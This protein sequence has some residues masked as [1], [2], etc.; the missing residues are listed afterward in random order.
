M[1][2][3]VDRWHL[4]RPRADAEPCGEHRAAGQLLVP[5]SEHGVGKRWQVR[6]RTPAGEQKK[7]NFEKQANAQKRANQVAHSLDTG[8]FVER[9]VQRENL[10]SVGERWRESSIQRERTDSNVERAL[11][12]HVYPILGRMPIA[13]IKR[14]DVRAWVKNRKNVLE[15][16]SL[17][18]PYNALA[19][20]MAE[21]FADGIIPTNPCRGIELPEVRHDEIV[22]LEPLVVQ[23]LI[24]AARGRYRAPIHLDASTGLRGGEVFGLEDHHINLDAMTVTVD[25]Q[26][27]GPDKGVP[28]LGQPKTDKSYRTLPLAPST[29]A[30]IKLHREQY[31]PREVWIEDRTDPRKPVWRYAKLLFVSETGAPVRRGSWAKLWARVVKRA[32]KLLEEWGSPLRVPE[33]TT[34]HDVRHFVASVLIKNGAT[35]K[36][37]QR[38]LGHAKPSITL[39]YYV[40]LWEDD[41]DDTANLMERV[42]TDVPS[43]C[44]IGP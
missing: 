16:I 7:E 6:Y 23:A 14:S 35:V 36:K 3:V 34:L 21:A 26:L 32:D 43:K 33:G 19:A 22:P 13:S 5:S 27:V 11:R 1:A 12:L 31:P 30:A 38:V 28:Y 29:G 9:S 8:T 41:E 24:E 25:Q 4:A 20:I 39:D 44:P 37:V 42:L 17:R 40:H 18:T 10:Q 15:P 2:K